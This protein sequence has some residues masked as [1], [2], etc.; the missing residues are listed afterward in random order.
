MALYFTVSQLRKKAYQSIQTPKKSNLIPALGHKKENLTLKL[1]EICAFS[2]DEVRR[3]R[4]NFGVGNL[5]TL[6]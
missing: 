4:R 2:S 3:E 1:A 6:V 5:E